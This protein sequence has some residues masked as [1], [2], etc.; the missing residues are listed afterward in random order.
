MITCMCIHN[1][2]IYVCARCI[3]QGN[4]RLVKFRKKNS[5]RALFLGLEQFFKLLQNH[6]IFTTEI[7]NVGNDFKLKT[8]SRYLHIWICMNF[9][10]GPCGIDFLVKFVNCPLRFTESITVSTYS[11]HCAAS[12][13]LDPTRS[14]FFGKGATNYERLV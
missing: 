3:A 10:T 6:N 7:G 5:A 8:V 12:K 9:V 1:I 13:S 4:V 2:C 11:S 14:N